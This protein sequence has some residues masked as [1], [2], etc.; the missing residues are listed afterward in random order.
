MSSDFSLVDVAGWEWDLHGLYAAYL[1]YFQSYN[2]AWYDR[3]WGHLF[4]SFDTF[5]GFSWPAVVIT[6]ARTGRGHVVT[7]SSTVHAFVR[8]IKTRFGETMPLAT[9]HMTPI[10]AYEHSQRQLRN[11]TDTNIYKKVYNTLPAAQFAALKNRVKI[12]NPKELSQLWHRRE[13]TFLA[14]DFEWSEKSLVVLEMGYAVIRSAHLDA[15]GVWPPLPASNYRKGHFIVQDHVDRIHNRIMPTFPWDY[16][17]GDSQLVTKAKIADV[18]QALLTSLTSPDSESLPNTLVLVAHTP[19][20]TIDRLQDLKVKLPSNIL[21]V[22]IAQYERQLF[23]SRNPN[24]ARSAHQTLSLPNMLMSQNIPVLAPFNNSGNDAFYTLL[25]FQYLIDPE[26]TRIPPPKVAQRDGMPMVVP[27]MSMSSV[28]LNGNGYTASGGTGSVRPKNAHRSS[29]GTDKELALN[30][31][32]GGPNGLQ[33][34]LGMF[35]GSMPSFSPSPSGGVMSGSVDSHATGRGRRASVNLTGQNLGQKLSGAAGSGGGG[36][37]TGGGEPK[38]VSTAR[39]GQPG[40]GESVGPTGSGAGGRSGTASPHPNVER[41]AASTPVPPSPNSKVRSPNS[42]GSSTR[43]SGQSSQTHGGFEPPARDHSHPTSPSGFE[44]PNRS[45]GRNRRRDNSEDD[46]QP[47]QAPFAREA[48][49]R[50]ARSKSYDD[51]SNSRPSPTRGSSSSNTYSRHHSGTSIAHHSS[52]PSTP[53]S[54]SIMITDHGSQEFGD[55]G[56]GGRGSSMSIRG[57]AGAKLVSLNDPPRPKSDV[58]MSSS[59][60]SKGKKDGLGGGSFF[61]NTIKRFSMKP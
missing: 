20:N 26:G 58:V 5:L 33:G 39:S 49:M 31:A 51:H 11:I 1:G 19:Q 2:I 54:P 32:M 25:M 22:D 44:P 3:S 43:D 16:A 55:G 53:T 10:T 46:F 9:D 42:S 8:M 50:N 7:R 21:I 4:A 47:P 17:W 61:A 57:S 60:S 45:P 37:G 23:N 36:A 13:K 6:D 14:L 34:R 30:G 38:S 41:N 18:L 56:A 48:A 27:T 29:A 52:G 12:G 35:N 15:S 59:S 40:R 28:Q 24:T